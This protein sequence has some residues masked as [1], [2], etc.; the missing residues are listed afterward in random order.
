MAT[1]NDRY[2]DYLLE[3]LDADQYP[4]GELLNRVEAS[5]DRGHLE[6]YLD[7]LFAKVESCHYPSVHLLD[8]IAR[9]AP[10]AS[11]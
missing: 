1:A 6:D 7:V 2:L 9:L 10:Y 8:R 5:L 11:S 3:R 4:S